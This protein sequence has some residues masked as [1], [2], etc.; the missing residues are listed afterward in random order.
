MR[1]VQI[2]TLKQFENSGDDIQ[3]FSDSEEYSIRDGE[4]SSVIFIESMNFLMGEVVDIVDNT[5]GGFS[6]EFT[7][8]EWMIHRDIKKEEEPEYF[9]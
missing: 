1:M 4:G 9:L 8:A 7:I 3:Q 2:K 6:N 5:H